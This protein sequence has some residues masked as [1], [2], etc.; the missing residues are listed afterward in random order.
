M[1]RYRLDSV[2]QRDADRPAHRESEEMQ[3][4][5]AAYDRVKEF[6]ERYSDERARWLAFRQ[7]VERYLRRWG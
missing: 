5:K 1:V 6:P 2:N 7:A 3:N 4:L